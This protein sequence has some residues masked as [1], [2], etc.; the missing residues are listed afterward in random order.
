[1]DFLALIFYREIEREGVEEV[2]TTLATD[3]QD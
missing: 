3:Q 2:K 1:M